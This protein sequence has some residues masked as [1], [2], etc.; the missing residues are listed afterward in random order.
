MN[1]R[2]LGGIPAGVSIHIPPSPSPPPPKTWRKPTQT[3]TK[4]KANFLQG[5]LSSPNSAGPERKATLRDAKLARTERTEKSLLV[6]G[7]T[8]QGTGT[9]MKKKSPTVPNAQFGHDSDIGVKIP[10]RPFR[11]VGEGE[12]A[13]SFQRRR[14]KN[15]L[16]TRSNGMK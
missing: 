2:D 13:R 11:R 5:Q 1:P 14:K 8:S 15:T 7:P 4:R 10:I 3:T 9:G 16:P 12:L 6:L